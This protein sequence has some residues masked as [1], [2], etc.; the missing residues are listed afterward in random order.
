MKYQ[1]GCFLS[2]CLFSLAIHQ[3]EMEVLTHVVGCHGLIAMSVA[4][5]TEIDTRSL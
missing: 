5:L 3:R 2:F 1:F 4:E